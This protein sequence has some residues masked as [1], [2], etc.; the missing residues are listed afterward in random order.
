LNVC[1]RWVQVDIWAA[2]VTLY[3][4]VEGQAPFQGETLDELYSKI[5]KGEY[6]CALPRAPSMPAPA[7]CAGAPRLCAQRR[8]AWV[9]LCFGVVTRV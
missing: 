6:R 3:Y 5:G 9:C 7:C 1:W 2:G 8:G 4:M